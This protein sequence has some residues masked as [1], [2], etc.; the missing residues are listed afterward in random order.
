MIELKREWELNV[1]KF[2]KHMRQDARGRHDAHGGLFVHSGLARLEIA[3]RGGGCD[4]AES[5]GVGIA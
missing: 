2:V 5:L 1:R 3:R 4:C